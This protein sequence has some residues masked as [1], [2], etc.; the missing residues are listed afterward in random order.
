MD[1]IDTLIRGKFATKIRL[2]LARVWNGVK[3]GT[4]VEKG[5]LEAVGIDEK[6]N[7]IH[8]VFEKSISPQYRAS[9]IEGRIYTIYNPGCV[10]AKEWRPVAREDILNVVS[11]CVTKEEEETVADI[12]HHYFE[13]CTFQEV[14]ARVNT[15]IFLSDAIGVLTKIQNPDQCNTKAMPY[16]LNYGSVI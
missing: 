13:W 8:V 3:Y 6:G 11:G 2:R 15:N 12:R 16:S 5:C 4:P 1:Y 9:I 14:K 10:L 7:A